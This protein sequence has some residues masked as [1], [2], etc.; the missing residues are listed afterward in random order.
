MKQYLVL[1]SLLLVHIASAQTLKQNLEKA[2]AHFEQDKQL[3]YGI[4]SLAV[5]NAS[6]GE[7][8][9]S[10]N[11]TTGLA[12]ASTLKTITAATALALLGENFTWE[13]IL[14]YSGDIV[15]GTLTGDLILKGGGDP[16][17][18]C[19]RYA[20]TTKNVLFEK[21]INAIRQTGIKKINGRVLVDDRLFGT[22]TL[23]E[24]WIWQDIGNYFGAGASSVSWNEN[25]F[26][27]IFQPAATTGSPTKLLHSEPQIPY[28][29]IINE[30]KTGEPG[31]GD[32]VYA[33]SAPYSDIIYL[34]GTYASDLKKTILISI[35]D[36]AFEI[37]FRL[38][39]TLKQLGI[40]TTNTPSTARR[41]IADHIQ[42]ADSCRIISVH[43]SPRLKQVIDP[44]NQKS[45]NLYG[46]ILIKT[47][48]WKQGRTI[49]T[50]EGVN[51]VKDYWTNKLGININA[52]NITDGS[53][54]S[55]ATR[56]TTESIAK[57]LASAKNEPW[58][59]T[60]Y[61]SLPINNNMKMKSGSIHDVLAYAGYQ[62]NVN[63]TFLAFSFIINNYNGNTALIRQKMFSVL[64]T[65]KQ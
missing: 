23:P 61:Q 9:F 48:A 14:G 44:F 59:N 64:N 49:S 16:T 29:K 38:Q 3:N 62:P 12:P 25:Q 41:L 35:P 57:I 63:G 8:I 51:I 10:K 31:S 52:M 43:Q 32:N 6:T 50:A 55:P 17:L 5:I 27:L 65:L 4:S 24:G 56:I 26:G 53:G 58:F 46:E 39:D 1:A 34:R 28:L 45:I 19:S 13:T 21:W 33:Y 37:A 54:L 7:L 2:Y 22:Q 36:P 40:Q 47:L 15:Q 30:V 42:V 20:Q 60:L 18:G 11:G